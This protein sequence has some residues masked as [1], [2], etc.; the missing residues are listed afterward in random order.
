[1]LDMAWTD[2]ETL[3]ERRTNEQFL[4]NSVGDPKVEFTIPI[5]W[6]DIL[7]IFTNFR[8]QEP[9]G[10]D[11]SPVPPAERGEYG[12]YYYIE[13]LSYDFL[14]QKISIIGVD[15]QY[16]IG[17]CM[18]VAQCGSVNYDW[19]GASESDKMYAYVGNCEE[20][21][22]ADGSPLKRVCECVAPAVN[23]CMIVPHAGSV[24]EKWE[25]ALH[26]DRAYAYVGNCAAGSFV[27][28]GSPLK[29]VCAC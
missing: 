10:L 6:I 27:S 20:G 3:I 14:N 7:D 25:D 19:A 23:L 2:S 8:L 13:S 18:I 17:Q 24:E 1:M 28:D 5:N 9:F 26:F 15:L 22:F 4:K 11:G 29:Q 21:S 12:R 16:L